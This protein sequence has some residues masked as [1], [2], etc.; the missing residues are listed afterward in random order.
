LY[1]S[2]NI[3][4]ES[5]H[6]KNV[7]NRCLDLARF[8]KG[9]TFQNPVV[10]CVIVHNNEIISESYH[11]R[12]GWPHAEV[13]AINN[14]SIQSSVLLEKA[15]MFVSL[16]P[17]NHAGKTPPCTEFIIKNKI[18]SIVVSSRDPN[19][20]VKGGGIEKLIG[21]GISAKIFNEDARDQE[22]LMRPYTINVLAERPYI[23]L[24][25]A[26]SRDGFIGTPGSR[27]KISE[28]LTDRLVH[29]W[30][31]E[32]D[33]IIVGTTTAIVDNPRLTN[34]L[35]SGKN[36]IRIVIDKKLM[37]PLD[38]HL[39]DGSLK[40]WIFTSTEPPNEVI[41]EVEFIE[42]PSDSDNLKF[43][44]Q[45]LFRRGIGTLL[46]EGGTRLITSF[47]KDDLWDECRVIE[48]PVMLNEGIVSPLISSKPDI[49]FRLRKDRIIIWNNLVED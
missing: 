10:G 43:I 23:I 3:S 28:P 12:F 27:I 17:C 1:L 44:L 20:R 35:Y 15:T 9:F 13:N 41:D 30:R 48:A 29:K 37:I 18:P 5:F 39:Y 24:K 16:E 32:S 45:T 42:M 46:V 6:F 49:Q 38:H 8:G 36:P 21:A 7:I 31:S 26:Q 33:A 14:V 19:P 47:L 11:K 2:K 22:K 40:T 25:W 4:L 34:R